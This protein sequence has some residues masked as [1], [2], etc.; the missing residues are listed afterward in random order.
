[1]NRIL[2]RSILIFMIVGLSAC[3][4]TGLFGQKQAYFSGDSLKFTG[5]LNSVF[6]EL[7]D[8]EKKIIAHNLED[9]V[10]KWSQG[11]FDAAHKKI[12]YAI[13]N[14][15]VKKKVRPYPDF[16]NY[17]N[18]LNIFINTNQ[19]DDYFIPW[20]D[21]LKKLITEKNNR[22]FFTFLES[23]SN[24]FAEN[25]VY[26]SITTRWKINAATYRFAFD[27]VPFIEFSKCDL[28]C[29]AYDDS[30][31]VYATRGVYY[32]LT[33][34]WKGADGLVNWKRAGEDP[35]KIF[36]ELKRY[37]IQMRSSK[38][39][40]DSVNFTNKKYF[41]SPIAGRYTDQVLANVTEDKASY[42]RFT[43]YDKMIGISHLFN[44]LD[45]LGG[46]TMEGGHV[47][48]TGDKSK[49]ARL[50]FKKDGK[51][52]VVAKAKMFIIHSDRI[53]SPMASITIYHDNDSIYHPGLQ[54]KYMDNIKE[55]SFNKDERVTTTSPWFDSYH[56]IE[57]Y[58]EALYWIVGQ[59]KISF[60]IMK[61]PSKESKAV[62]E[63]S[64]YY[65][66]HRYEKL[67]GIDEINPL[68]LIKNFT[69]QKKSKEFTL[70]ELT[71]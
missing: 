34:L 65:S 66:I 14:E 11:K 71:R 70:Q 69:D 23:T 50:F 13:F 43:S 10:Q 48:G 25:L 28:V 37:N 54:L 47:I 9:F 39:T 16:F 20:S 59:P 7:A 57:I 27:S 67:K 41:P 46:F 3:M 31:N 64:S 35:D 12:I 5:E 45:Y 8:N 4:S 62:F 44:N 33:N 1:M 19:P 58:C 56:K 2:I 17:I 18:S 30:L 63:S 51:D 49:D 42:P 55:L 32:P 15:M 24:L 52:F 26:K 21:I 36:A 29:F 60:E 22:K 40:A 61:G 6:S 53:N 68:I 38:F